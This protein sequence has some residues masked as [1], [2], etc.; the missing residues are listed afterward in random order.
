MKNLKQ[1]LCLPIFLCVVCMLASCGF[2]LGSENEYTAKEENY[3][4]SDEYFVFEKYNVVTKGPGERGENFAVFES[5]TLEIYGRCATKAKDIVANVVLYDESGNTVGSYRITRSNEVEKNEQFVLS[6][7]I[8]DAVLNSF[9]VVSVAYKGNAVDRLYRLEEIFCNVTYVYNN[10]EKSEMTV[11]KKGD[12]LPIP[13]VP[14]KMG[15]VFYRWYTDPQC[16]E[17][18]D[19]YD[20]VVKKDTVLYAGYLL[21][22]ISM[23]NMIVDKAELSTV[24]I[25]AKSY[26]SMLWGT[27]EVMSA[28]QTGEGVIFKDGWGYYYVLT[29]NDLVQKQSG[30]ENVKYTVRDCYGNEYSAQLKHS[31]SGYNLGVLYFTK[32]NDI[33]LGVL[34]ISSS[35]PKVGDEIAVLSNIENGRHTPNFGKVLSYEKIEH[36]NTGSEAND[37]NYN[38]MVHSASTD[39]SVTGRPILDM[40]LR[41]V[42]IQC[43]TLTDKEVSFENNHVIPWDAIKKYIDA[44]GV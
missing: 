32:K 40:S 34:D 23:G 1:K 19:F 3:D 42:G 18:F 8:S 27:I 26:T 16:T 13:E 6:V 9:S 37:T 43:G 38:M 2:I 35:A 33:Q 14:E 21:D 39:R 41:L 4:L 36:K 31:G 7:D 11:V 44:Y 5:N 30:Y 15:Y 12:S 25:T 24:N 28:E 17:Y 10:G 20:D 29:T 22:Y